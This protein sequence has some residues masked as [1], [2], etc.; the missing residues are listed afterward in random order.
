MKKKDVEE[1]AVWWMGV[2]EH[3]RE[4]I[5]AESVKGGLVEWN[6]LYMIKWRMEGL[7]VDELWSNDD[8]SGL[9]GGRS[10]RGGVEGERGGL[11]RWF[12]GEVE[13]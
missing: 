7:R 4:W 11:E 2:V 6:D 1:G 5:A 9:E 3:G 10:S 12:S 13:G 8:W